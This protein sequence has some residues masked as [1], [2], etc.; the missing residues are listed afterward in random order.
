MMQSFS[1]SDQVLREQP[2]KQH[3]T[4]HT[5]VDCLH[6]TRKTSERPAYTHSFASHDITQGTLRDPITV[7]LAYVDLRDCLRSH[8]SSNGPFFFH[9]RGPGV[10]PDCCRV[11]D[12]VLEEM[13]DGR[14]LMRKW[15]VISG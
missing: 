6:L 15:V 12:Y 4:E 1:S 8:N 9:R 5:V 13:G 7:T 14:R 3:L 10:E 11:S 2:L